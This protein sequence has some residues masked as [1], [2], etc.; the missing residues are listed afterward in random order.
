MLDSLLIYEEQ[1][2][3]YGDSVYFMKPWMQVGYFRTLAG[4]IATEYSAAM[5][6]TLEAVELSYKDL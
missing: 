2:Y 1:F 4:P 3:V 5:K 6:S